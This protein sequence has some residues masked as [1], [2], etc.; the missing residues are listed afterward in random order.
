MLKKLSLIT[1]I[2]I[3]SLS[4]ASCSS[5]SSRTYDKTTST[6]PLSSRSENSDYLDSNGSEQIVISD[7]GELDTTAASDTIDRMVIFNSSFSLQ[8][9]D[10]N[11]TEASLNELI[12]STKSYTENSNTYGTVE[13]GDANLEMTIRVPSDKYE[14]FKAGIA[15]LGNI[16]S[17]SETGN[18]VT[19]NYFDT[20][21]RLT[22]L[23]AQEKRV[24][25]LLTNAQSIEDILQI[26]T[27]LSRIRSEI[28][29][30]TTVIKRY[31]DLIS[32]ST[33]DISIEQTK[34]Y[35]VKDKTF[36]DKLGETINSS[37][38]FGLS[39]LENLAYMIVWVLPYAIILGLIAVIVLLII[40]L[41]RKKSKKNFPPVNIQK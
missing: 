12:S 27:E 32:Y 4:L 5:G 11:Q 30:L 22:V 24:L 36:F 6:P 28:E 16:T 14:E 38:K 7:E 35:I 26:E 15:A 9:K 39:L 23:Q 1:T 19:G 25:E 40:K 31:D 17:S 13:D 20:E 37:L 21:A 18:D 41:S 3:M 10:Y 34:D 8:T 29:Q 33:I 2:L